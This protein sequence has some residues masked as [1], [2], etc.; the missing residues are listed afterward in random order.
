M[1]IPLSLCRSIIL[2][3]PQSLLYHLRLVALYPALGVASE[4]GQ[5]LLQNCKVH[6]FFYR[7][8]FRLQPLLY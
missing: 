2:S 6:H 1:G 3:Q 4:V 7:S 5:E 8:G